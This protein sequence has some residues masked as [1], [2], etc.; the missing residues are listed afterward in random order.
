MKILKI[1]IIAT[2]LTFSYNAMSGDRD[3]ND[4]EH[5]K[6]EKNL[7]D[8]HWEKAHGSGASSKPDQGRKP[9]S[10]EKPRAIQN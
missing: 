6:A 7:D 9:P 4:K 8:K 5:E 1:L 3:H 10:S 2:G